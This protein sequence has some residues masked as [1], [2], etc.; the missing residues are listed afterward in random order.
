MCWRHW[1]RS[2]AT[3]K[4][5]QSTYKAF[6]RQNTWRANK[7]YCGEARVCVNDIAKR[8]VIIDLE[9]VCSVVAHVTFPSMSRARLVIYDLDH[10]MTLHETGCCWVN[11]QEAVHGTTCSGLQET[12]SRQQ[13][14]FAI[15]MMR[16]R[17]ANARSGVSITP[18]ILRF[19]TMS[20]FWG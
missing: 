2:H 8:S 7:R 6:D 9:G 18:S 4:N 3:A 17:D 16:F 10:Q 5:V 14:L 11:V 12:C 19:G 15:R 13:I 1:I 20:I